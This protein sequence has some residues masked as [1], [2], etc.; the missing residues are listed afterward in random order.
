VQFISLETPAA[1]KC[2]DATGETAGQ[3]HL[4]RANQAYAGRDY[5][6][7]LREYRTAYQLC[8]SAMV[9]F[10]TANSEAQL[11]RESEAAQDFDRFLREASDAEADLRDQATQRLRDLS[12]RLALV[13]IVGASGGGTVSVDRVA[14]G[15][16][17]PGIP[18][19]VPPGSHTLRV[20]AKNAGVFE[21]VLTSTAGSRL[22][23]EMSIVDRDRQAAAEPPAARRP[24]RRWWLWGGIA[25]VV[26]AGAVGAYVLMRPE[27]P[28]CPGFCP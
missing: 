12:A 5:E 7:A 10:G 1:A 17:G 20:Y 6:N 14:V 11:G 13:E 28:P 19:Y 22:R 16:W 15:G 26:V 18:I 23:L 8:R 24:G 3:F 25:A 2:L 4:D 21:R 27:R 9:F